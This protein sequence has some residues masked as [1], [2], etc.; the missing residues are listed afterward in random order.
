MHQN[1]YTRLF[2]PLYAQTLRI[3]W[4][5]ILSKKIRETLNYKDKSYQNFLKSL[6]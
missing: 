4:N 2:Y 1:P 6:V 3:F 5:V